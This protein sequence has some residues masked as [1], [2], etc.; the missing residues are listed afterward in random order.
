MLTRFNYYLFD[1]LRSSNTAF[2]FERKTVGMTGAFRAHATKRGATVES[3]K[4]VV[5]LGHGKV[6]LTGP[7]IDS[8][9]SDILLVADN[10]AADSH[11]YAE[12]VLT[13]SELFDFIQPLR[14]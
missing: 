4:K 8:E 6:V 5:R 13:W 7:S 9:P 14:T 12:R 1:G 2:A 10:E 11:A 3:V